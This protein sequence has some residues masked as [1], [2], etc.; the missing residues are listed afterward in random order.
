MSRITEGL[1]VG[2]T[3]V[4]RLENAQLQV[5]IAPEVG[6]RIVSLLDL[7]S[8]HQFLWRNRKLRLQR[9]A[10]GSPY[11]P[12]F[13]GGIDEL[14]P[15]DVPETING[16]P[17]P[18]HGEL[19]TTALEYRIEGQ[20]LILLGRLPLFGLAYERRMALRGD[21]AYLDMDYSLRNDAASCRHFMW[22]L[23][24]ALSIEPGDRIECPARKA[25]VID[26][27]WT[28]WHTTEPFSWPVIEGQR[29]DLIPAP[30]GTV[31]FLSL[32]DL[33]AGQMSWL[34]PSRGLEFSYLF[35]TRVFPYAQY[36]ASFG[37]LDGHYTAVLEPCTAM[38]LLVNEAARL[39]Q[40]SVLEPG[41]GI[42]TR[43]IIY[44]GETRR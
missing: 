25:Q 10:P 29:A 33:D 37:G 17:S 14:I 1:T 42:V 36:F 20:S 18:D 12:N 41:E 26:P 22:K 8:G 21:E 7:G 16:I 44:A 38:P 23:H 4:V 19:W 39:G 35:D 13:L 40:C 9:S 5:D 15:G 30:D 27:R 24:A 6:G 43:I 31:D 11:D 32:Y 34:S 3:P 2:Q 28:R